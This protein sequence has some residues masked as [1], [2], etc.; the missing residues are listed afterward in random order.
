MHERSPD[1]VTESFYQRGFRF[2]PR[3][4][5]AIQRRWKRE[6][7]RSG[8]AAVHSRVR[9]SLRSKPTA[10]Y[11]TGIIPLSVSIKLHFAPS[12]AADQAF[13]C[14]RL[15]WKRILGQIAPPFRRQADD[16]LSSSD[17]GHIVH[18]RVPLSAI[19]KQYNLVLTKRRCDAL[20]LRI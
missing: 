11:Y 17:C 3:P 18:G 16:T 5:S 15:P 13:A 8:C 7:A 1:A 20:K 6:A 4:T 12:A 2:A 10:T 14:F 19:T 9:R